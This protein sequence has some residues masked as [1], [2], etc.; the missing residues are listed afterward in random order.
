MG[1]NI[2]VINT[3]VVALVGVVCSRE[4][5]MSRVID[6]CRGVVPHCASVAEEEQEE[7]SLVLGFS[8]AGDGESGAQEQVK[9][10]G[11]QVREVRGGG[12]EGDVWLCE[13]LWKQ[14][15]TQMSDSE[16]GRQ[17]DHRYT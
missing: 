16:L 12:G 5:K 17:R 6:S 1:E 14:K 10:V 13:Q 11:L 15:D 4:E 9:P 7:A 3:R 8:R 2:D